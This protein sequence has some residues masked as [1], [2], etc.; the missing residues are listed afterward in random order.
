MEKSNL[1][2]F[3]V[4]TSLLMGNKKAYN[5]VRGGVK[6]KL[7]GALEETEESIKN[8]LNIDNHVYQEFFK[9]L[10]NV[11]PNK[12]INKRGPGYDPENNADDLPAE[13]SSLYL[14]YFPPQK[15][16]K[17]DKAELKI[18]IPTTIFPKE[19]K[20]KVTLLYSPD[21]KCIFCAYCI[22]KY[23]NTKFSGTIHR[24]VI[25]RKIKGLNPKD[26]EAFEKEG[27]RNLLTAIS[28]IISE[29]KNTYNIFLN[30]TGGYKGTVPYLTLLG[31]CLEDIEVIYLFEESKENITLPKMPVAF[32]LFTWRN[33]RGFIET[34]PHLKSDVAELFLNTIL[35]PQIRGLFELEEVKDKYIPIALGEILKQKYT[36]EKD[37]ELTQYGRGYLLTEKIDETKR[38]MLRK[39]I[40]CWQYLWIG[41]RIP[42]TVEHARGHTQRVLE[43]SAQMLY[44]ILNREKRFFGDKDETDNNLL[45]LIS[46]I[47]LH[48]LGHSGDYLKWQNENKT[49]PIEYDIKGFPSLIRDIH[50]LLTWYLMDKEKKELFK[51]SPIFTNLIEPIR[52]IS[53]YNRYKMPVSKCEKYEFIDIM[54]GKPLESLHCDLV[55]LPLLGALLRMADAG[56]VQ[57]ERTISLRYETMRRLQDKIEI[58]RLEEEEKEYRE[59]VNTLFDRNSKLDLP[60]YLKYLKEIAKKYFKG[61]KLEFNDDFKRFAE[62]NEKR[63]K[64]LK[65]LKKEAPHYYDDALFDLLVDKC[66]QNFIQ[67]KK[68][69]NVDNKKKVI[70]RN[71]LS[72]LNQYIFKKRQPFHFEKH[73]G[74]S[75]VMYLLEQ[76]RKKNNENEYHFKV[77]A[78][79]KKGK[80]EQQTL[81]FIKNVERV[82]LKDIHDEYEKVKEILNKKCIFFDFLPEDGG[83]VFP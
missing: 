58:E 10:R 65:K 82:V 26:K 17:N 32:D 28:E 57:R 13:L 15:I 54:I 62:I 22:E 64:E 60:D 33:Y 45:V 41:D 31:M 1:I 37:G 2:I 49:Q 81:K 52:Q 35:P 18:N 61:D 20:D 9:V 67:N 48:D 7:G 4:G 56:D 78:I 75:V 14:F 63:E 76:I 69:E 59:M 39:C 21:P 12:Q 71:W 77:L 16:R 38:E 70:L 19:S 83:R 73:K 6:K 36:E 8:N 34:V 25:M 74:I 5:N 27:M 43:L 68:I 55:D 50:H 46:S 66:V 53:L 42:E 47:W 44:P 79:H 24:Q 72:T 80:N 51:S 11:D 23:L 30:V 3:T 29:Y 40:D